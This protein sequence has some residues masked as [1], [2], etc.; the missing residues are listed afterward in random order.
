MESSKLIE[1]DFLSLF[2]DKEI[3][4]LIKDGKNCCIILIFLF[5]L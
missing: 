2:T 3:K 4:A 5:N 1:Y